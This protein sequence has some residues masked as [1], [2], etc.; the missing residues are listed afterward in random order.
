[1]KPGT[2]IN[3]SLTDQS[4]SLVIQSPPELLDNYMSPIFNSRKQYTGGT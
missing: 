4:T 1:M 2:T 3:D